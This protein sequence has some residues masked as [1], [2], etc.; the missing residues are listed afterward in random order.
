[1]GLIGKLVGGSLIGLSLFFNN[2]GKLG[3]EVDAP[4]TGNIVGKM[5]ICLPD[6]EGN[7]KY[8]GISGATVSLRYINN[9]R[10][11]YEA[12]SAVG[13][14][15]SI[16]NVEE[17]TYNYNASYGQRAASG[18]VTVIGGETTT[19]DILFNPSCK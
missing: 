16:I 11:G 1:M 5:E 12:T 18:S 9:R 6:G 17:R 15:Y 4:P 19:K 10:T 3:V 2:C 8:R 14:N 7:P 13:G